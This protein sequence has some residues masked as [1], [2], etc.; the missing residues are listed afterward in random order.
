MKKFP[1]TLHVVIEEPGS[2]DEPFLVVLEEGPNDVESSQ[3]CAIY[4]LVKVGRVKVTKT[5]EEK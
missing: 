2:G 1:E 4:Q 3:D 5:F